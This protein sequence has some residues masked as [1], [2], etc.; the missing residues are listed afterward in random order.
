M[1]SLQKLK[2]RLTFPPVGKIPMKYVHDNKAQVKQ[3][4]EG[5]SHTRRFSNQ[6]L[7]FTRRLQ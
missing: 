1:F 5:I 7:L 6:D 3:K 2:P 4:G